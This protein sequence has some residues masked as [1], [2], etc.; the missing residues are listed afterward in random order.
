MQLLLKWDSLCRWLWNVEGVCSLFISFEANNCLLSDDCMSLFWRHLSLCVSWAVSP[1]SNEN[2]SRSLTAI[3]LQCWL[4]L[5]CS[6]LVSPC[7]FTVQSPHMHLKWPRFTCF[8]LCM[9]VNTYSNS[10]CK[11]QTCFW[12]YPTM[13][14]TSI[15]WLLSCKP[16]WPGFLSHIIHLYG[17]KK[18]TEI[19]WCRW[20]ANDNV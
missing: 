10:I 13:C 11:V 8:L 18:S 16:S 9:Q 1:L 7:L 17:L 20:Y 19:K 14:I 4:L 2:A 3:L 12:F 5:A 6:D 15:S